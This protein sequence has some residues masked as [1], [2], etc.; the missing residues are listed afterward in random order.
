MKNIDLR[1]E[2]LGHW[3]GPKDETFLIFTDSRNRDGNLGQKPKYRCAV[4]S[5][6]VPIYVRN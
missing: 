3:K 5:I 2:C 6:C 1:F 4:S